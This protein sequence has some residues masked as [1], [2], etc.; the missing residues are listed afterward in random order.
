MSASTRTPTIFIA[1][2]E[3]EL[4]DALREMVE[5]EGY[6]VVGTSANGAEAVAL[7][8]RLE[9]DLALID[10]RM[11]G[12]DGVAVTDALRLALPKIQIIMFTAYD[13][14][15]LSLDATR[16]GVF[17]FL[18]KGCAPSLILQ[19][20]RSAWEFRLTLDAAPDRTR[21]IAGRAG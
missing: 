21:G 20:L 8:S 12:A 19:A 3:L 1:E 4:Q 2:D 13:E 16:A 11:P 5:D 9:P 17:A 15:S 7:A 10:Y 14:T 18:V 6:D